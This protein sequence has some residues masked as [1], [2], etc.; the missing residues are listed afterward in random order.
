MAPS[1]HCLKRR[2]RI[3]TRQ[4]RSSVWL[5]RY[6]DTVEVS[7]SSPLGPTMYRPLR[8][9][10]R[11]PSPSPAPPISLHCVPSRQPILPRAEP[12]YGLG[13]PDT[14]PEGLRAE[15]AAKKLPRDV[16]VYVLYQIRG[17]SFNS[18]QTLAV[19]PVLALRD[20]RVCVPRALPRAAEAPDSGGSPK[21]ALS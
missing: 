19:P 4:A 21:A 1:R 5:E 16:E 10:L 11:P 18:D 15:E 8:F 9:R 20:L 2:D 12:P 3:K 17:Q 14:R 7:G 6:L 13:S